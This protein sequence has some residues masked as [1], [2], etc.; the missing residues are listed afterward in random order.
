MMIFAAVS[1]ACAW[2]VTGGNGQGYDPVNPPDPEAM[3]KLEVEVSP[4]RLGG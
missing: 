2:A 3:F 4:A 1:I